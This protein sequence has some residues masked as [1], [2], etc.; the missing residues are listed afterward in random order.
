[1]PATAVRASSSNS[2]STGTAISVTAPT[3]TTTGD[4]VVISVHG[5][6]Q[7]TIVDNN[8]AT[9]FTADISNYAPNTTN[10]HT[11]SI[12]SRRIIG[13]DPATYNFTLGTTNRWSIDAVTFSDP[14]TV[15]IY[16]VT[17]STGNAANRD[18]S[19][20]STINAP[21]I[22]TTTSDAIHVVCGY[23]DDGSGGAM[24]PP[25]GY[26]GQGAPVNEPQTV[27]TKT[28]ASASA[29]GAQTVTA[30]TSSPMIALSFAVKNNAV[31]ATAKA[32]TML[33]MGI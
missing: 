8:G 7:T 18:D 20:A 9:P 14:D 15:T 21:T 33:M 10:G 1:M 16:D 25:S 3:G 5:N 13:G 23:S 24:T 31:T 11:V 2:A 27:S 29:T 28:I 6:G 12:Y 22:T 32:S 30:T 26:T 19:S 17:P 4:L